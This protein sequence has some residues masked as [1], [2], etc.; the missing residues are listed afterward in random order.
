MRLIVLDTETTG[1]STKGGDRCVDVGLVEMLDGKRT[2][3]TWQSY[4]D[5][6]QPVN[7]YAER[8]HGLSRAFL[9][10][11]PRF[12]DVSDDLLAFIDGAP[13]LAHNA[14]FDRD[15][16]LHDFR[17]AGLEIPRLTFFDTIPIAKGEVTAPK[18]NLDA[19]SRALKVTSSNRGVHGALSD[20][21]LLADVLIAIET[22]R[23]GALA[24]RTRPGQAM[25]ALP[26]GWDGPQPAGPDPRSSRGGDA[27]ARE[28]E[29]AT[30]TDQEREIDRI[31]EIVTG[32]ARAGTDFSDFARRITEAGV[33]VR[34][35]IKPDGD[36]S[37]M[38]FSTL[39]ASV[40]G[41]AIGMRAGDLAQE[42][43]PFRPG[44][45]DAVA[46]KL[47]DGHDRVMGPVQ[48]VK[49]R[50]DGLR[51]KPV[52]SPATTDRADLCE[53]V[54]AATKGARTIWDV[55][56]RLEKDGVE[57]EMKFSVRRNVVRSVSFRT[58]SAR[59]GGSVVGLG[60]KDV[61][62]SFM[63]LDL[64]RSGSDPE[65]TAGSKGRI[66]PREAPEIGSGLN[67]G[68]AEAVA[69]ANAEP[70]GEEMSEETF[71]TL[72]S[73]RDAWSTLKAPEMYERFV[74][75][76]DSRDVEASIA[77]RSEEHQAATLRWMGRGLTPD[78]AAARD[79]ARI[80][81]FSNDEE[82]APVTTPLSSE[83][84]APEPDM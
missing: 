63:S 14:R 21:E 74:E 61:S 35:V 26:R 28:K 48:D 84:P 11:H 56:A 80:R 7:P 81:A 51:S 23:P 75:V 8:V 12:G 77:G 83:D 40:T 69:A 18:Y 79:D 64:P 39:T 33:Y 34:P 42:G 31:A 44:V 3:R 38:R 4:L 29:G 59:V 19:L 22:R 27:P 6:G 82:A 10:G 13:C 58:S 45:D 71:R 55:A 65:K 72:R 32:A 52:A 24:R 47:R 49:A 2:G 41:A 76:H 37:G 70:E 62:R 20:A 43:T 17:H 30:R 68:V 46:Y 78:R 50:F 54:R 53:R 67:P 15:M 9:K 57:T 66:P 5:P 60:A 25:S 1:G 73:G 16:L 36:L